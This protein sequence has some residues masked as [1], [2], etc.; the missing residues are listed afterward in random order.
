MQIFQIMEFHF[1]QD[2]LLT[3]IERLRKLQVLVHEVSL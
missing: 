1:M 2:V 3:E